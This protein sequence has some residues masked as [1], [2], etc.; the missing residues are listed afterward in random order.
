[1]RCDD[2]T[3]AHG[4]REP[5]AVCLMGDVLRGAYTIRH[6]EGL[7]KLK[8]NALLIAGRHLAKQSKDHFAI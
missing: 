5:E 1:M 7:P 6:A 2:R 8:A 3:I 4:V